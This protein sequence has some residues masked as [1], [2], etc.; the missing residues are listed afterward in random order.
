[1]VAQLRNQDPTDPLDNAEFLGQLAQFSTVTGIGDLGKS[2]QGL[3]NH[4][5]ASQAMLAAQLVDREVLVDS[6]PVLDTQY[7]PGQSLSG[8]FLTAEPTSGARVSV[9][10]AAGALINTL[11]VGNVEPGSHGFTW[12]GRAQDG[13]EAPAG[14]YFLIAEGYVQGQLTQLPMQSYATVNS[15]SVDRA[16]MGVLLHLNNGDIIN[17]SNVDEFK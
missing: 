13:S 16:N 5:F 6:G 15:V 4:L 8:G 7:L 2:F 9:Y 11:Q 10:D 1:M 17:F 3:V 12:S 14:R